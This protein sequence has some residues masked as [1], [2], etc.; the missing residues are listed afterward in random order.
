M[1]VGGTSLRLSSL[2]YVLFEDV[3]LLAILACG[4]AFAHFGRLA[5]LVDQP[6]GAPALLM[7]LFLIK[8]IFFW[9]GLYDFRH[10]VPRRTFWLRIATAFVLLAFAG[11][12]LLLAGV[13]RV[14]VAAVFVALVP[15]VVLTRMGYEYITRSPGFR[16]RILIL[17]TG[18]AAQ[19]AARELLDVHHRDLDVAGF[20]A[21]E[22]QALGWRIGGRR[23]LGTF[24]DL[25]Q[26]VDH[27][28]VRQV[29]VA[30]EDRRAGLPL[31]GLLRLRLR[32]VE[33][34]EEARVHE[35]CAGKI[36]IDDLRPSWL[37]FSD[38]F[39]NTPLRNLTKRIF[40]LVFATV[41]IVLGAPLMLLCALAIRIESRGPVIFRQKRV[42]RGGAEFTLYKFRSMREDAEADGSPQWAQED[43][44]RVTR[45]GRLMRKTRLDEIPQ[46]WNVLTGTMSFVGPRPERAFFV[47]LLR[48]KIPYYDQRHMLKP[49]ITGWAQVRYRYGS[50]ESD[51]VEKLR[52]DMYYFKYHSILFD[53]RILL[54]T[55]RVVLVGRK[56][57]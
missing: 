17:G 5:P 32:G 54:E 57:R 2:A 37:I 23:V 3:M 33:I 12:G 49:G 30:V 40:D 6:L 43:D 56:G 45:V 51:A 36:P 8:G 26:I 16:R 19:R 47:D 42:G 50:D 9:S 7:P 21:Q 25:E 22:Q 20:L 41:G 38:G 28:E 34:V 24:D 10:R 55:V 13:N 18:P 48:K 52:H 53:L 44:P 14:A 46:L 29:V 27:E 35:E 39:N 31:D 1:R 11:G 4:V 15:A